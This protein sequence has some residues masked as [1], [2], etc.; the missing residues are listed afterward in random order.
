[1]TDKHPKLIDAEAALKDAEDARKAARE[2]LK[3]AERNA[4]KAANEVFYEKAADWWKE[5]TETRSEINEQISKLEA[6]LDSKI[7]ELM[8]K[9]SISTSR[10][11]RKEMRD[12]PDFYIYQNP[13]TPTSKAT[14][15]NA[16]WVE[17]YLEKNG[18]DSWTKLVEKANS[19]RGIIFTRYMNKIIA[20]RKKKKNS[21]SGKKSKS[22]SKNKT[23]QAYG[24][25][26]D[27]ATTKIEA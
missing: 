12:M 13:D 19:T 10:I 27:S 21:K 14:T 24:S 23:A 26:S 8:E 18:K 2:A 7:E 16:K 17:N 11:N 9:H 5:F 25:A 20:D 15:K 3:E 4:K 22:Q 1:M 6:E